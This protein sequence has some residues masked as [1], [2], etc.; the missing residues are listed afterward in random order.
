MV[1]QLAFTSGK[2]VKMKKCTHDHITKTVVIKYEKT[3]E[4]PFCAT[5]YRQ[6]KPYLITSSCY[7]KCN[8]CGKILDPEYDRFIIK[9]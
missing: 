7:F 3:L 4:S 6:I 1:K 8:S 9:N 5:E 2:I